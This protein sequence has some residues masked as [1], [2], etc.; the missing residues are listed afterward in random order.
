M[1]RWPEAPRGF[2]VQGAG[3]S[4]QSC[5]LRLIHNTQVTQP[6]N[7]LLGRLE[8]H[9]FELLRFYREQGHGHEVQK[10]RVIPQQQLCQRSW[11]KVG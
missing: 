1:G 6:V 9:P 5:D 8:H 11:E 3:Q 4:S 10:Q 7:R 2:L